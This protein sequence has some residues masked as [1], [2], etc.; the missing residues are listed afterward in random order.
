MDEQTNSHT[1]RKIRNFLDLRYPPAEAFDDC[2]MLLAVLEEIKG[3]IASA[4][5]GPDGLQGALAEKLRQR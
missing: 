1:N 3:S 2:P 5:G 4:R